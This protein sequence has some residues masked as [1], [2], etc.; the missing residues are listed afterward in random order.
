MPDCLQETAAGVML[1]LHV[2]PRSSKNQ[3][4]G[5]QGESLKVKLCS[6]PVDG[7]A[8]KHCCEYLAKLF[9]LSRSR[10]EL[11]AGEKARQKRVLLHGVDLASV[12]K[13]L[14]EILNTPA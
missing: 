8:N 5:F 9:G 14:R 1:R 12:E 6:P 2:Q 3:L 4:V 10:V 7:A 13:T 11:I